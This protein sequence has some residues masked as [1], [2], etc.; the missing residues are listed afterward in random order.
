MR[1]LKFYIPVA[2]LVAS[3]AS[4]DKKEN[5]PPQGTPGVAKELPCEITGNMQLTNHN[6]AGVDYIVS[7]EVEIT[8]GT[9]SIDPDVTIE[10]KVNTGMN[11]RE[12]ASISAMGTADKPIVMR[13]NGVGNTWNGINIWSQNGSSKLSY[14]NISQ[15]GA[16]VTFNTSLAGSS[17]EIKSAITVWHRAELNNVTIDGSDGVGLAVSDEAQIA[18][19][20][21]N[22]KNC[23]QQPIITYAGWL[24]SSFNLGSCTFSGNGVPYIALYSVTSNAEVDGMVTIPKA[25]LPYYA[26]RSLNFTGDAVITAG[27]EIRFAN[28]LRMGVNDGAS[29]AINGTSSEPVII[30]GETKS[31]GFWQGMLIRSN[32]PKNVFNYLQIADGGSEEIGVWAG[33]TNIAV[34]DKIEEARVTLNHCTSENVKG[35]CQVTVNEDGGTLVNNS[36]AITNVCVH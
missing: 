20:A 4:C 8:G 35:G 15:A 12:N 33:K 31:P 29:L 2:A 32:N 36:S 23:A 7:C 16:A 28:N 6:A 14:C 27:V 9:L 30:R 10:F 18:I 26:I 25:P 19:S 34:G 1:K 5:T 13:G 24:N 22:I 17:A 21:L 11:V 3:F